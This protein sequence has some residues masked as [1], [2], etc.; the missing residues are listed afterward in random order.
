M[1]R[2][3]SNNLYNVFENEYIDE[4][5]VEMCST[6]LRLLMV[7]NIYMLSMRIDFRTSLGLWLGSIFH[8]KILLVMTKSKLR[9]V[10]FTSTVCIFSMFIVFLK[11][12][13]NIF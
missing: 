1:L 12:V 5:V 8:M 4:D 9:V 7:Y 11:F 13:T 2:N 3:Y 10:F 6:Q